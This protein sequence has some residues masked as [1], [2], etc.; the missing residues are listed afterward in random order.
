ML[1]LP[2]LQNSTEER[3]AHF[4]IFYINTFCSIKEILI[5]WKI[6][7]IQCTVVEAAVAIFKNYLRLKLKP[8]NFL[9]LFEEII[10]YNCEESSIG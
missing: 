1:E 5:S 3:L 8:M 9:G 2:K 4:S 10:L 7:Q 6:Y